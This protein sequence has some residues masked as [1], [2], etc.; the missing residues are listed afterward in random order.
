[1]R[2]RSWR[3]IMGTT[4]FG[5]SP[6]PTNC[7]KPQPSLYSSMRRT[8]S[9][10]LTRSSSVSVGTYGATTVIRRGPRASAANVLKLLLP[11]AGS[12]L[13]G[14]AASS[15]GGRTRSFGANDS[16]RAGLATG[17]TSSGAGTTSDCSPAAFSRRDGRSRC[18]FCVAGGVG[19]VAVARLSSGGGCD[20]TGIVN[21][22]CAPLAM[23]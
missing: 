9:P 21:P 8:V 2:R 10:T 13:A 14:D 6:L 1:M 18:S 17:A 19:G 4:P 20:G 3:Q 22:C 16:E 7:T 11:L 15:G 12:L 23:S 5:A